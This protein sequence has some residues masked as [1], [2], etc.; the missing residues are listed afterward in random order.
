MPKITALISPFS[1]RNTSNT[2]LPSPPSSQQPPST[3]PIFTLP[4]LHILPRIVYIFQTNNISFII[5][6]M[7]DHFIYYDQI[8]FLQCHQEFL[9]SRGY[10]RLHPASSIHNSTFPPSKQ[11][12]A[13]S[14]SNKKI[15]KSTPKRRIRRNKSSS[16]APICSSNISTPISTS[17]SPK[18][19]MVPLPLSPGI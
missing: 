4:T 16:S 19:T 3:K 9:F 13:N 15:I 2:S 11:S 8:L 17:P 14:N 10:P 5:S 7:T 12:S 1:K 18:T 6:H